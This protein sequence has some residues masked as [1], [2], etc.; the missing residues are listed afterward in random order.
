MAASGVRSIRCAKE[1]S[2]LECH[3]ND[4]SPIAID[5]IKSNLKQNNLSCNITCLDSSS[6]FYQSWKSFDIIDLDPFGSSLPHLHPALTSLAPYGLLALTFTDLELL[7]QYSKRN[8]ETCQYKY[9][10]SIVPKASWHHE[11]AIR[12]VIASIG[13]V[14]PIMTFADGFYFRVFLQKSDDQIQN[15]YVQYC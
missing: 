6:L 7:C 10:A 5:C 12:M 13:S 1:I 11:F 2:N 3:I 8:N 15:T 9:G 4:L 14:R